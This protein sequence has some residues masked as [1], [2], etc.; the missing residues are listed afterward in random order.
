MS[1]SCGVF[2]LQFDV[3][4]KRYVTFREQAFMPLLFRNSDSLLNMRKNITSVLVHGYPFHKGTKTRQE[5]TLLPPRKVQMAG[6]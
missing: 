2:D 3:S 4:E 1:H 6:E 5:N